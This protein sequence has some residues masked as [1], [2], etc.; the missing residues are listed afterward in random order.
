MVPVPTLEALARNGAAEVRAA[1]IGNIL[2]VL[3]ARREE[4]YWQLFVLTPQGI[5]AATDVSDALMVR[6]PDRLPAGMLG[7]TGEA[8][9]AVAAV[10]VRGRC[11]S[12]PVVCGL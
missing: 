2:A 11:G 12:L 1:G 4:V 5:H 6:L 9:A 10:L 8:R 3:D 7:I